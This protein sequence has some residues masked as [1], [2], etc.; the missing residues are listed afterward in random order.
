VFGV[1]LLV[2]V[3]GVVV[4]NQHER[5]ADGEGIVGLEDRRVLVGLAQRAY[6]EFLVGHGGSSRRD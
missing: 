5:F 2:Q 6:I 1:E 3:S 4:G